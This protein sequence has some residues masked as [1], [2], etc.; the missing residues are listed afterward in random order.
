MGFFFHPPLEG[1]SNLRSKFGEGYVV[2][3]EELND[4]E[5]ALFTF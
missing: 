4:A 2:V 1:G 5:A 3:V